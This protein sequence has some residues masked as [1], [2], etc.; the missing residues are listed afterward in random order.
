MKLINRKSLITTALLGAMAGALLMQGCNNTSAASHETYEVRGTDESKETIKIV[1]TIF[2][3][4]DWTKEI[5]RDADA[6]IDLML[7]ADNGV[8]LHS[9][10]PTAQDIVAIS[11][12]DLFIYVGGESDAWVDDVLKESGND[13]MK[14][15]NLLD[16]LSENIKEEEIVEG[17]Q[18][19]KEESDDEDSEEGETEYDEHVWLSLENAEEIIYE[20]T[21]AVTALDPDNESVYLTN[22]INYSVALKTLDNQYKD[23]VENA[24]KD[25]I[26]FGDRF[27]FRYLTDDY[28]LNYYAAFAGCS[29]ETEADFETIVFLSDKV[30]ELGLKT[31]LVTEGSDE[32]IAKTIIENTT[33]KDQ[34]ILVLDSMQGIN[35]TDIEGG[36]TYL[37]IMTDN[38]EIL[39]KA[40]E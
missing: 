3:E 13:E 19:E 4:Y 5:I 15:I 9:Y 34:E 26:L 24:S 33:D 7:L 25:T 20:I 28:N 2:P 36:K 39:K 29:A 11:D 32:S 6:N 38:L 8:D 16:V 31:V 30:N 40:L 1:T 37:Q 18:E 10:Q 14:V 35:K 12:A 23:A 17:M 22:C 21:D 27:P